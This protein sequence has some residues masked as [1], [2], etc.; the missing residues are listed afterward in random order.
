VTILKVMAEVG[1]YC[2][3]SVDGNG[4]LG[5]RGSPRAEKSA[6]L[7]LQLTNVASGGEWV[8]VMREVGRSSLST[9]PRA[10]VRSNDGNDDLKIKLL[11]KT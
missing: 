6:K 1:S 10:S 4:S 8:T 9:R 11:P 7:K 5:K 3:D 2:D